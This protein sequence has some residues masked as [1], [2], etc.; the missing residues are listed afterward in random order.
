[1]L[2]LVLSL[3]KKQASSFWF[4]FSIKAACITLLFILSGSFKLF[5]SGE[6]QLSDEDRPFFKHVERAREIYRTVSDSQNIL[7][8]PLADPLIDPLADPLAELLF[9]DLWRKEQNNRQDK[10]T[11]VLGII[12]GGIAAR[13]FYKMMNLCYAENPNLFMLSIIGGA[14]GAV[15]LKKMFAKFIYGCPFFRLGSAL[16]VINKN[17]YRDLN[18]ITRKIN[19]YHDLTKQQDLRMDSIWPLTHIMSISLLFGIQLCGTFL[20]EKPQLYIMKM[21]KG[22]HILSSILSVSLAFGGIIGSKINS[23]LWNDWSSNMLFVSGFT[24]QKTIGIKKERYDLVKFREF[25]KED[26]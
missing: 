21:V 26:S 14:G 20:C 11:S 4:K 25:L 12:T 10:I 22:E 7:T 24:R 9:E 5:A 8:D 6:P 23:V 15:F 2:S 1:M 18:S 13:C 3:D 19:V 17:D 16:P